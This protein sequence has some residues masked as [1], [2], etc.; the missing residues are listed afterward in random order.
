MSAMQRWDVDVAYLVLVQEREC[1]EAA[2]CLSNLDHSFSILQGSH[3]PG[4]ELCNSLCC[5]HGR[6][7]P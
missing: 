7:L 1:I 2:V 4:T 3:L 5:R 6:N